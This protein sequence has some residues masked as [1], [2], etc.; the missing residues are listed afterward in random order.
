MSSC[1]I[2]RI[3]VIRGSLYFLIKLL[4]SIVTTIVHDHSSCANIGGYKYSGLNETFSC[5]NLKVY[6][7]NRRELV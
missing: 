3:L 1:D 2:F 4:S 7:L 6:A 5:E